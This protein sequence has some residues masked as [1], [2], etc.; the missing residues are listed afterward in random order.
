[1]EDV[2]PISENRTVKV[3]MF[4]DFLRYSPDFAETLENTEAIGNGHYAEHELDFLRFVNVEV[5]EVKAVLFDVAKKDF[6]APSETVILADLTD[7]FA[8]G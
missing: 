8:R 6:D 2:V 1:M 5:F 3:P 4:F 7:V